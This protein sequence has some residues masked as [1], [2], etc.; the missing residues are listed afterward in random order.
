M[1]ICIGIN[2]CPVQVVTGVAPA[3]AR[4]RAYCAEFVVAHDVNCGSANT[5]VLNI[6]VR[7]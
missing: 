4:M 2:V 6:T 3:V 5:E 1:I 7:E